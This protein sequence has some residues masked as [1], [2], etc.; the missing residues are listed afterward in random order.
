MTAE[1]ILKMIE[2]VDPNDTYLLD[3]IDA[4]IWCWI[5]NARFKRML[6]NK[7]P[8]L[9]PNKF[10]F[11]K[12]GTLDTKL[13]VYEYKY[14]RSRDVL[15]SMRPND[16]KFTVD[17]RI[18]NGKDRFK[19]WRFC[20]HAWKHI[21]EYDKFGTIY[22]YTDKNFLPTE[23]LAELHAIIQAIELDRK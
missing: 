23:E 6:S 17:H 12:N 22:Y 5:N 13:I 9:Q 8:T 2:V 4:R 18:G 20:G 15:K 16:W 11:Y 3:E 19:E 21:G 10:S 14:T 1:D 7:Y